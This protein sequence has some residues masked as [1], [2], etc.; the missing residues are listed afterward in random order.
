MAAKFEA[1]KDLVE[2]NT[3]RALDYTIVRPTWYGEDVR[4]GKINTGK[5]GFST[6]VSREDVA[7]V[8]VACVENPATIGCVFEVT[9]GDVPIKEAVNHIAEEKVNS[10]EEMYR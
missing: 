4:A 10:F 2:Q 5:T 1:D 3:R 6:R 9:G 8:I 7:D